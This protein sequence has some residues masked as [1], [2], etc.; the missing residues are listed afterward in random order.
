MFNMTSEI[1]KERKK[2]NDKERIIK[3]VDMLA[4]DAQK[5]AAEKLTGEAR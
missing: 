4:R 2:R 5:K 3:I 1:T